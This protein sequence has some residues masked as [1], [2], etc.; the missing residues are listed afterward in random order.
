LTLALSLAGAVSA[1]NGTEPVAAKEEATA[2]ESKATT[3]AVAEPKDALT[4]QALGMDMTRH[5]ALNI[6]QGGTP[7]SVAP[8][9]VVK[10]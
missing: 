7:K 3:T 6:P 2:T 10:N 4:P 9:G 5:Y 1:H 8:V